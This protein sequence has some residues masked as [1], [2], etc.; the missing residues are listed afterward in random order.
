MEQVPKIKG[1]FVKFIGKYIM[2][3]FEYH[4]PFLTFECQ[5]KKNPIINPNNWPN[6]IL[7]QINSIQFSLKLNQPNP[8][9]GL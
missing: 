9:Y 8:R 4:L 2:F 3:M 5:K 7:T 6:T 1:D